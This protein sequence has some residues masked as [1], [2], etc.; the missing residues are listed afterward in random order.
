MS[1]TPEATTPSLPSE[2]VPRGTLLTL[3][4]IPAG[5]LAWVLLWQ[6]G[7]V[8]SIVA[9]G[10]AISPDDRWIVSVGWDE[11]VKMWDLKTGETAWTWKRE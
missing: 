1:E 8:A 2:N 7:L 4:I 5:I 9:F 11:Q 3:L 6:F 10:V